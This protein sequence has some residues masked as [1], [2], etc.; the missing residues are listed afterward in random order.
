[1]AMINPTAMQSM[2]TT[3]RKKARNPRNDKLI[4]NE[5]SRLEKNNATASKTKKAGSSRAH[6]SFVPKTV[7]KLKKRVDYSYFGGRWMSFY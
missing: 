1:M 4:T 3:H 7:H 6:W 5:K 2:N